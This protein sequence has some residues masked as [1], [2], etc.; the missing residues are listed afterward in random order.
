MSYLPIK[1]IMEKFPLS[2]YKIRKLLK[3]GLV[4]YGQA[5]KQ[6]QSAAGMRRHRIYLLWDDDIQDYLDNAPLTWISLGKAAM[7]YNV[8][9][10]AVKYWYKMGIVRS[11]KEPQ[12]MVCRE[13]CDYFVS[14]SSTLQRQQDFESSKKRSVVE[15]TEA[16]CMNLTPYEIT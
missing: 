7:V 9:Y 13:D 6:V 15:H 3:E 5:Y 12:R 16:V 1:A 11:Q 2:E 14:H 8:T 4:R 10:N